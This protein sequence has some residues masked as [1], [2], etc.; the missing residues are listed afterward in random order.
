MANMQ[1]QSKVL[2]RGADGS[3]GTERQRLLRGSQGKD[4]K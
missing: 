2:L 1:E 3:A 4:K